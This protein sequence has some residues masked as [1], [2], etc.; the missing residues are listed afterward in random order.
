[1][2]V[3]LVV[4]EVTMFFVMAFLNMRIGIVWGDPSEMC[5][6]AFILIQNPGR[7]WGGGERVVLFRTEL[8]PLTSNLSIISLKVLILV[9]FNDSLLRPMA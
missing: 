5:E 4:V 6:A 3:A 2:V 1:M 7:R 9:M 8:S